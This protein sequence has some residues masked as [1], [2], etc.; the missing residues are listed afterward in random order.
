M[1]TVGRQYSAL[2][3]FAKEAGE[4]DRR[5]LTFLRWLVE[6]NC[7]EHPVMGPASGGPVAAPIED[8]IGPLPLAS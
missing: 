3:M 8:A 1:E 7:L 6:N 4:P 2:Q 5:R